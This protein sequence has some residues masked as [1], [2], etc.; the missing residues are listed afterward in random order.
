MKNEKESKT[1][2]E[3]VVDIYT[4]IPIKYND[5][6]KL[7]INA[8]ENVLINDVR[9]WL[10]FRNKKE[11]GIPIESLNIRNLGI[12]RHYIG[13]LHLKADEGT[14]MVELLISIDEKTQC[15]VLHL[16]FPSSNFP[17]TKYLDSVSVNK[18]TVVINNNGT[19][20]NLFE[21]LKKHFEIEKKGISKNFL[22]IV[23]GSP[24]DDW[25]AS[26]LF[27]EAY[28]EENDFLSTVTD[29]DIR[30]I[31]QESGG[32]YKYAKTYA[33]RNVFV[34][35]LDAHYQQNKIEMEC[36]TLFYIELILFEEAAIEKANDE[37]IPFLVDI[38]KKSHRPYNILQ[39]INDILSEY[40]HSI[41]FWNVQMNYPSSQRS[42]DYIR[43]AFNV[44]NKRAIFQRNQEEL[45]MIYNIQ[46]DMV[47]KEVLKFISIIAAIFTIISA[48]FTINSVI[49][50]TFNSISIIIMTFACVS[51]MSII[52]YILYMQRKIYRKGKYFKKLFGRTNKQ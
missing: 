38:D 1:E 42:I 25:L 11:I 47:D 49:N 31:L 45:L 24:T 10:N 39:K 36:I 13:N 37:I 21:Y 5:K 17:I 46:S 8:E 35:M 19:T 27:S 29:K 2:Q 18:L 52:A 32:Q 34:Q 16:V 20:E 48:A 9:E 28:F 41:N 23:E 3:L 43:T 40:V 7:V 6:Q 44:E 22:T 26:V 14:I 50:S 4:S 30:R 15:G 12:E 33:Y 51:I